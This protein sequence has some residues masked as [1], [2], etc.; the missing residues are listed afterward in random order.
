MSS[1]FSPLFLTRVTITLFCSFSLSLGCR[2]PKPPKTNIETDVFLSKV[3]TVDK[4][5]RSM[6]GPQS[7]FQRY[8]AGY[9]PGKKPEL[10]W[11]TGYRAE[12]V[13]P[14]GKT[15]MPQD[16]MCHANLNIDITKH[17]KL[18]NWRKT[19]SNRL[20]TL[21]QGQYDIQFPPG[22]GIPV[23]SSEPLTLQ[24]Q[25]LNLNIDNPNVQTR[26]RVTISYI[27]DEHIVGQMR[28][29]FMKA[30]N[31]LV[32]IEGK[33]GFYNTPDKK[34]M[35]WEGC[36][37][38]ESASGNGL[39][40]K[41]GR[42]FSGHWIVK[43]GK[44]ENHTP[45][46]YYMKLPYD[47]TAHYIAVHLHPF[48]ES[49]ELRDLTAKK[50][51]FKSKATNPKNKIGLEHVEYYSNTK[52]IQLYKDHE[53]ELIS[54]YNNTSGQDQDSMA[55]MF[56]YVLDKDFQKPDLDNLPAPTTNQPRS[57]PASRPASKPASQPSSQRSSP[58][59]T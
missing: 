32:L 50:T 15:V 1:Y 49:L 40:D 9:K 2:P 48:A 6:K 55:V 11:I 18:F 13:S 42:Q 8:L 41:F 59:T 57:R 45:S 38:G 5:Y 34:N 46:T 20:F 26:H 29:L 36:L 43:P 4:K 37:L 25:V 21:S 54:I 39:K 3:Y 24:T 28:P 10:L 22:F 35:Q 33:D 7:G 44:E 47:T 58:P 14:D 23:L 30:A 27:R 16:F 17:R 53:Y 52:G 12:M 31:G 51:V 19:A 56:M